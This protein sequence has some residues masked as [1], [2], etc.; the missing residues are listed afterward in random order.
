MKESERCKQK[1]AVFQQV[2]LQTMKN[3]DSDKH[4][5]LSIGDFNWQLKQAITCVKQI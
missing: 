4:L 5:K 1:Q 2:V 3:A